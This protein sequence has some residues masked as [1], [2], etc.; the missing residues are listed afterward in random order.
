MI[1]HGRQ[2]I[3]IHVPRTG[4]HS[5]Y[6]MLGYNHKPKGAIHTPRFRV[7][8]DYFSFGFM[9]NPWDRMYSCYRRQQNYE[10]VIGKSFK[11]Y[12]ME[13]LKD[14][15]IRNCCMWYLDGCDYIGRY[16]SLQT[17]WDYILHRIGLPAQTVP[18]INQRGNPEYR[19]QYD[20][21]MI[22]FIAVNHAADIE[23]GGYTFE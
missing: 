4:G 15:S 20:N 2:F 14:N 17:G 10:V 5:A 1:D 22:D 6:K 16:E 3:F 9:R 13:I 18:H 11:Y 8:E 12:L 19:D 23:Y 21:E 7:G